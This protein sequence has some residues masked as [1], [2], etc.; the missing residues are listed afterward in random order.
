LVGDDIGFEDSRHKVLV[1]G[2][3][4]FVH[5][6][7]LDVQIGAAVDADRRVQV[8]SYA[9]HAGFELDRHRPM[10]RDDNTHAYPRHP[11]AHHKHRCDPLDPD[12]LGAVE[13]IDAEREPSLGE[14]MDELLA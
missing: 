12:A 13:W 1:E 6:L 4:R 9:F 5:G 14:V 11:D 8:D 2:R 10:F 7:I 3:L